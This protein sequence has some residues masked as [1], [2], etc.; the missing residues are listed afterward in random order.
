MCTTIVLQNIFIYYTSILGKRLLIS[1]FETSQAFFLPLFRLFLSK[2][3]GP[4]VTILSGV[5]CI[6]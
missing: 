4:E 6:V 3:P 1:W 5:Y 2:W